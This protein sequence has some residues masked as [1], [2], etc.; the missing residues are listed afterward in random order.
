VETGWGL[1]AAKVFQGVPPSEQSTAHAV[2][3]IEGISS[4]LSHPFA[5]GKKPG[6]TMTV[7][8]RGYL[9]VDVTSVS[10]LAAL[11]SVVNPIVAYIEASSTYATHGMNPEVTNVS[12]EDLTGYIDGSGQDY[13]VVNIEC[14]F[15]VQRA[16]G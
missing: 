1:T 2:I 3:L 4:S 9:D 15:Q 11:A 8:I 16:R 5:S 10:Y 6:S 12:M 14:Q 7:T 13:F